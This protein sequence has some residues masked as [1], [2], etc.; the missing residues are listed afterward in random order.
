MRKNKMMR[1]ASGLLVAT[2]LTTS[3]ISGTFAKYTTS[4]TG[5]DS[6]RVAYWGFNQAAKTE[7]DL[8]SKTYD[9]VSGAEKVVAPGTK[10]ETTFSFSYKD[11]GN[12]KAPEVAYTLQVDA[13]ATGSYAELDDNKDFKWTLKKDG[14]TATEYQTVKE[15]TAAVEAL[16]GDSTGT[17]QYAANELPT[18]LAPNTGYT[19]G[20]VWDFEDSGKTAAQDATDTA[21]GNA[22]TLDN[23]TLTITITATQVD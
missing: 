23:V 7:I 19:I 12:I 3:V 15:L 17:K 20:W 2:L 11:N 18:T 9:N 10:D 5:T 16:S 22:D 14:E 13:T 6:A 1:A 21:M 4:T 8:F